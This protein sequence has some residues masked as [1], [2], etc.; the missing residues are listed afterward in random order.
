MS[1]ENKPENVQFVNV[2]NGTRSVEVPTGDGYLDRLERG[3][4]NGLPDGRYDLSTAIEASMEA[5]RE[6][7]GHALHADNQH[8]FQLVGKEIVKHELTEAAT[9]AL[10]EIGAQLAVT[11]TGAGPHYDPLT[12]DGINSADQLQQKSGHAESVADE[13]A[14]QAMRYVSNDLD[15]AEASHSKGSDAQNADSSGEP[16]VEQQATEQPELSNKDQVRADLIE[17]FAHEPDAIEQYLAATTAAERSAVAGGKLTDI[18]ERL[19]S[20]LEY[21]AALREVQPDLFDKIASPASKA[22]VDLKE[23]LEL[24]ES[25]KSKTQGGDK[26]GDQNK[27]EDERSRGFNGGPLRTSVEARVQESREMLARGAVTLAPMFAAKQIKDEATKSS[28]RTEQAAPK[29]GMSI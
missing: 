17:L 10:P 6:Y 9:Q 25:A 7:K 14:E 21:A 4:S 2:A 23:K 28:Q 18:S 27:D 19:E 1:N 26:P 3:S 5:G 15:A 22:A 29:R 24:S 16:A 12:I 13:V 11:Y 8:L 20:R